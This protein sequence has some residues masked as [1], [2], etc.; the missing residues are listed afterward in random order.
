MSGSEIYR[1]A[2]Q[3]IL[4]RA[5]AS[6]CE[7]ST[8]ARS[9]CRSPLSGRTRGARYCADQWCDACVAADALERG[10]QKLLDESEVA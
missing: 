6:G 4:R 2:L 3:I 9:A 5:G 7:A 8:S 10:G 1:D